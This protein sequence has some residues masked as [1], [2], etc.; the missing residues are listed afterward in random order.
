[1]PCR[2]S[3][4]TGHVGS[5]N[6]RGDSLRIG[7]ARHKGAQLREADR[8]LPVLLRLASSF[9]YRAAG[10]IVDLVDSAV[11]GQLQDQQVV[12]FAPNTDGPSLSRLD[13]YEPAVLRLGVVFRRAHRQ[14]CQAVL[15]GCQHLPDAADE[16]AVE[17]E[18]ASPDP[19]KACS[20][21][22]TRPQSCFTTAGTAA[23]ERRGVWVSVM[24]T[25]SAVCGAGLGVP[26]PRPIP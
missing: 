24:P 6:R 22:A 13:L 25:R 9:Q 1:M 16:V 3:D 7:Y 26:A 17:R 8:L 14:E 15:L 23:V 4:R 10:A 19:R 12:R 11:G 18:P 2:A 5:I 20:S 21:W